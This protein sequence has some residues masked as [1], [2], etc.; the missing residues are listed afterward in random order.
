V[1]RTAGLTRR[2]W[3]AAFAAG[4]AARQSPL[5]ARAPETLVSVGGVPAHVAGE[6]E[7]PIAFQRGD[8]GACYVFDRRAHTVYRLPPDLSSATRIVTI[9]FEE[10]RLLGPSAFDLAGKD[11]WFVVADAPH[12]RERVQLFDRNGARLAGF[13]LPGRASAR[14][15]VGAMVLNGVGSLAFTGRSVLINQPETGGLVTEYGM[16]GTPLR[17]FGYLRK[18]GFESDREVHLAMNVG[19]PVLHPDGGIWFVFVAGPPRIRRYDARGQLLFDRVLQGRELDPMVAAQ[20][21]TW[22]RRTVNGEEL[23]LVPPIV[24]AAAARPNG[25]LWVSFVIPFTYVIDADGD[26]VR[27]VQFRATGAILP[28][29]LHFATGTRLFV[30]P[31]LYEFRP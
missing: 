19:I 22:P 8:D 9:G 17:T 29:S 21:T 2:Q 5:E 24:R 30:T 28:T 6:F 16:S 10:G 4:A 31:G 23:P 1:T 14:M 12:G 18:T 11:G 25:Q 13:D 26:Q 7:E 27:T 3:L 15:S 20:P